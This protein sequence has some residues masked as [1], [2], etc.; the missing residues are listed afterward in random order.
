MSK[1]ALVSGITGQDASYLAELLLFKGYEVHGIMRRSSTFSTERIEHIYDDPQLHLHYG[2]LSD[3]TNLVNLLNN[4]M[5]DEIYHLGAMSH[6]RA[7]FDIPV[8]TGD[9]TGLGTTRLLEAIR[10]IGFHP[11]FYQA[12]SSEMFGSSPPPQNEDTP[13]RPQSP[14]AVAKVYAYW[15]ARNYRDGYGLF[16]ANGILNNHE[17]SR[18]GKTFVTRK[19]TRAVARIKAGTQKKLYLGNLESR[20]DWGYT[21]EYVETMW[22]MLQQD[23]PDDY[24]IGTGE[25]HSVRE[26][27]REAFNYV[28]LDWKDFV[29]FDKKY[30]RPTEVDA[31]EADATKAKYKL[32]WEPKVT[33]YDLVR[34]MVDADLQAI[35]IEPIGE[36]VDIVNQ[37]GLDWHTWDKSVTNLLEAQ[38]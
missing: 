20:R 26:F 9:I 16:V 5:P 25:S 38:K 6:V 37:L 17:S 14:Y 34:I 3:G 31:L 10:H 8:Y 13:F 35:G 4:I 22:R 36:G 12:S 33:F 2:D 15:M 28:G 1:I 19:I 7:S 21:P 24:V 11:R 29:K 32:G 27:V 30:V 18:R 23:I